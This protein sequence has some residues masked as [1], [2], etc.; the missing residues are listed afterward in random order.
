[1]ADFVSQ[2][3]LVFAFLTAA[4]VVVGGCASDTEA[5][6]RI[7]PSPILVEDAADLTRFDGAGR[8]LTDVEFEASIEEA[9][10][11]CSFDTDENV[12]EADMGVV[13]TASRGPANSE[14]QADLRYFV[15][16]ATR[17]QRVLSRDAFELNIPFEGNRTRVAARDELAPRIPIG[18]NE[19][20][21]DYRIY[22]GFVLTPEELQY[23]RDNR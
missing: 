23:N 17:D 13:I 22:I 8:D 14:N 4:T 20:G 5:E 19:D 21:R 11:A 16:V 9:T 15:A 12:I 6:L 2:R 1:M 18:P 3:T 7:C 10:L